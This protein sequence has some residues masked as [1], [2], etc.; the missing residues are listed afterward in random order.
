M[1]CFI[2]IFRWSVWCLRWHSQVREIRHDPITDLLP[3]TTTNAS[4]AAHAHLGMGTGGIDSGL[5]SDAKKKNKMQ[6]NTTVQLLVW[7][8]PAILTVAVL[9]ARVIDADELLGK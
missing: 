5:S 9:I 8:V 6:F 2:V 4:A 1:I 7:G 3:T